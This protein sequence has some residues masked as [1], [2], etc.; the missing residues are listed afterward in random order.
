MADEIL[1]EFEREFPAMQK[2]LGF[3]SSLDELDSIFYL[4]DFIMKEGFVSKRLSRM[5]CS[6]I[7]STFGLWETYFHAL[8]VPNPGSMQNVEE[9]KMITEADKKEMLRIM[10]QIRELSTRNTITGLEGSDKEEA[11]LIDD[12]VRLWNSNKEFFTKLMKKLNEG[13]KN[14]LKEGS[15]KRESGK[16]DFEFF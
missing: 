9:S 2:K 14:N 8:I 4:R 15:E 1:A 5:V 16:K 3:K 11:V 13:W 10:T 7:L 12:S 6:R